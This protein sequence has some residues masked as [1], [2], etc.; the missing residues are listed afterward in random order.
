MVLLYSFLC[1]ISY[2]I[3]I[4]TFLSTRMGFLKRVTIVYS[5]WIHVLYHIAQNNKDLITDDGN[6][7][8]PHAH[9]VALL[10]MLIFIEPRAILCIAPHTLAGIRNTY[11]TKLNTSL[12]GT[13]VVWLQP[14]QIGG[15]CL[16]V[17]HITDHIHSTT[18][19]ILTL[20]RF[21][22]GVCLSFVA[23]SWWWGECLGCNGASC[24]GG[25]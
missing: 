8:D 21:M 18:Y 2:S 5:F 19:G 9:P 24:G 7:C 1:K 22:C 3:A 17:Q 16:A 6:F 14:I 23:G 15:D 12:Q 25:S 11:I 10:Y 20:S 13:A 4:S